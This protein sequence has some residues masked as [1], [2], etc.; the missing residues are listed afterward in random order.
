MDMPPLQLETGMSALIGRM[1]AVGLDD[2]ALKE[3]RI[4]KRRLDSKPLAPIKAGVK[5][6][7]AP[8]AGRDLVTGPSQQTLSELLD[9][10][11]TPSSASL[12]LIIAV[13]FHVLRLFA[14]S[15]DTAVVTAALPILDP[16]NQNSPTKLML[17]SANTTPESITKVSRQLESLAQ[18]LL[19]LCPNV[20]SYDDSHATDAGLSAETALELQRIALGSRLSWWQLSGHHGD[21]EGQIL[22]PLHRCLSAFVRRSTCSTRKTYEISIRT[23]KRISSAV[24]SS[25]RHL[26]DS[27]TPSVSRTYKLLGTVAQDA[28]YHEEAISWLKSFQENSKTSDSEIQACSIAASLATLTILSRSDDMEVEALLLKV[29]D[30]VNGPLRGETAE[31]DEL[32]SAVMKLRKAAITILYGRDNG[33][34]GVEVSQ[35]MREMCELLILVSPRFSV[36]YLGNRPGNTAPTKLILRHEQRR[37]FVIK[38]GYHVIDSAMFLVK[39]STQEKRMTWESIDSTLQDCLKLLESMG[40]EESWRIGESAASSSHFVRISNLYYA[41]HLS[42]RRDAQSPKDTQHIRALRRSIDC[43]SSQ[44]PLEKETA[45]YNAKLERLA[46]MYRQV[47]R[48]DEAYNALVALCDELIGSGVLTTISKASEMK[49]WPVCWNSANT[50]K[51]LAR[52]YASLLKLLLKRGKALLQPPLY[53]ASWTM[54]ERGTVLE[55]ILDSLSHQTTALPD[56]KKAVMLEILKVYDPQEFPIRRLRVMVQVLRLDAELRRDV[57]EQLRNALAIVNLRSVVEESQDSGLSPY[58]PHLQALASSTTEIQE[59]HPRIDLLKPHLA[60]WYSTIHRCKDSESLSKVID[61]A[62]GLSTHLASIADFLQVKGHGRLRLGVLKLMTSLNELCQPNTSMDDMITSYTSL[63]LQYLELGYSGK[64]SQAFEKAY[65]YS[66]DNAVTTEALLRL[67]LSYGEHALAS[68]NTQSCEEAL[69]KVQKL[70]T[71]NPDCPIVGRSS[72]LL[73]KRA[74]IASLAANACLVHSI[75]AS[76][77]GESDV[78]LSEAK[79]SVKLLRYSWS[80]AMV[81]TPVRS[82]SAQSEPSDLSESLINLSI[83]TSAIPVGDSTSDALPGPAAWALLSPLFKSLLNL[84]HIYAYHGMFQETV[85]YAEQAQ[86][87]VKCFHSSVHNVAALS[88]VGNAWLQA[89]KLG[90]ASELL[91]KAK[92]INSPLEHSH[93]SVRLGSYLGKLHRLLDDNEAELEAYEAANAILEN[94]SSTQY[95]ADLES[96][97]DSVAIL[98]AQLSRMTVKT[99][100]GRAPR[101]VTIAKGRSNNKTAPKS[102]ATAEVETPPPFHECRSLESLRGLLLRDQADAFMLLKRCEDAIATLKK[103]ESYASDEHDLVEQHVGAAKQLLWQSKGAMSSDP[104]YSVLQDSTIS[105]PAVVPIK[106]ANAA[107]ERATPHRK[108]GPASSAARSRNRTKS[109]APRPFFDMLKQA[110]ESLVEAH[111]V[112]LR[113]SPTIVLHRLSSL[114]S[115][116]TILMSAAEPSLGKSLTRPGMVACAIEMSRNIAVER[117]RAAILGEV[118]ASS[119]ESNEVQWPM[120]EDS[121][122]KPLSFPVVADVR[123]FQEDYIN[124]LPC[125]WSVISISLSENRDELCL[126]RMQAGQ[127]PFVLRLPLDRNSSRDVDEESFN[128]EQGRAELMEIIELANHSSHSAKDLSGRDAK[129]AWWEERE[130]LDARLKDLL[131]NVENVWLGGFKGIF[132]QHRSR[133]ELLARFQKSL[134][135]VLDKHLPSRHNSGKR[136]KGPKVTLDTR[137]LELF[138]GLKCNDEHGDIDEALTDLLYFVIDV[139]QFHGERNAYDEIDFDSL[140]I[141]TRDALESYHQAVMG[142]SN[143]VDRLHTILILDKSLHSFPWESLPCMDGMAVSRVPSLGCLRDSLAQR[144]EDTAPNPTNRCYVDR[145]K[146]G[147]I[148]NPGGDLKTTQTTF[149]RDLKALDGWSG[150]VKREPKESDMKDYLEQKDIL[151]YFG[152]GSGAQYIRSKTI[153]R[154]QKCAVAILMGCSSGSLVEVGV[155]EPY[156]PPIDYVLASCPALVATLWD[157]TDKDIDRFAK[158]TFESWG[159]FASG[160]VQ[161]QQYIDGEDGMSLVE[162]VAEGRKACKFRYLTAAAVCVYGIPVYLK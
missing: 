139:L 137:I 34:A 84:S 54:S 101:K 17:K 105:Y 93:H 100:K 107:A 143:D 35:G 94:L 141:E 2:L 78:A 77:R 30:G 88:T 82:N 80:K 99:S 131:I 27:T 83:S 29:L 156:G 149:E 151:L 108:A 20:S 116:V 70:V 118:K 142:S 109:P 47:G 46:D 55:F 97:N 19:S 133:P 38:T 102:H 11:G 154:L 159:L 48:H 110:H 135:N 50:S 51:L 44:T 138:T 112:A 24:P 87:L 157:V 69:Y 45:A 134:E 22:T 26:G 59:D 32:Y 39:S 128:F 148:L 123:A 52:L 160:S 57:A 158:S 120:L 106:V 98:E 63:G 71:K 36:R 75:L 74:R 56:I 121:A 96:I 81:G 91:M 140:V 155:F 53:D 67:H 23:F 64:A 89:G 90:K 146:G 113:V 127:S 126:N 86:T 136:S 85:Y 125:E 41:Q 18:L 8:N 115:A 72:V 33:Y 12:A 119:Q 31:L 129:A 104:V 43:I 111:S 114:L 37:Q 58:L 122:P 60:F 95:I 9:F 16:D 40:D 132:A 1:I 28:G 6:R 25:L 92:E 152:H 68:G 21:V 3:L 73:S 10:K 153:R 49:P 5:A 76:A 62:S 14:S 66:S 145:T 65:S 161:R 147:Y 103:A 144:K 162:A 150:I 15:K 130:A 13:Q 7:A 117:E 79:R 4:L 124:I 42:M 61:D